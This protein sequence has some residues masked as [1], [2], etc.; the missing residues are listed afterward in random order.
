MTL[1][2]NISV[3]YLRHDM[4]LLAQHFL[5]LGIKK[6]LHVVS[7]YW[8][9]CLSMRADADKRG[10][11]VDACGAWAACSCSTVIDIF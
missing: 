4:K 11:A 1:I 3:L 10:N 6:H 9:T 7:H 5:G 2:Y 8:P